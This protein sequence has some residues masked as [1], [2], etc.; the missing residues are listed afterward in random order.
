TP[1]SDITDDTSNSDICQ[2]IKTQL[3]IGSRQCSTSL[4][5]I[6][7]KSSEDK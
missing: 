3:E 4:I 6:G 1:A 7:N 2:G 5:C